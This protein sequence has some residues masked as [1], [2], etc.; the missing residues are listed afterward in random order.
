MDSVTILELDQRYSGR[1]V[2]HVRSVV[3]WCYSGS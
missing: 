2:E 3:W 1:V